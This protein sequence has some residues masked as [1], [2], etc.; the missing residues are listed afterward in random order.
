MSSCFEQWV[1]ILGSC[2]SAR[3]V[4]F[5]PITLATP[6]GLTNSTT[7]SNLVSRC[8]WEWQR[9]ECQSMSAWRGHCTVTV[10][11]SIMFFWNR[12]APLRRPCWF[13]S[14]TRILVCAHCNGC[15]E[16]IRTRQL[17]QRPHRSWK[18][19]MDSNQLANPRLGNG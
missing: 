13:F 19:V 12:T 17:L 11:L 15:W 6:A 2:F 14:H 3:L 4:R 9:G 10:C 5:N 8:F 18:I 1:A 16:T 7:A